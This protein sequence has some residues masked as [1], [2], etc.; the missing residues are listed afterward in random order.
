MVK[1]VI[2][3]ALTQGP[4]TNEDLR[5]LL[6]RNGHPA[7]TLS[8]IRKLCNSMRDEGV[9]GMKLIR[10]KRYR[11][12]LSLWHLPDAPTTSIEARTRE[13]SEEPARSFYIPHEKK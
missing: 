2:L 9:V 12:G 1:D 8:S 13:L 5:R 10:T 6:C 7:T 4:M 3:S 11:N